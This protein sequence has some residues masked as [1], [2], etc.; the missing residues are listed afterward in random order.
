MKSPQKLQEKLLSLLKGVPALHVMP[1]PKL[2]WGELE[3]REVAHIVK[4]FVDQNPDVIECDPLKDWLEEYRF[5][6]ADFKSTRL[7]AVNPTLQG[8]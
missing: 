3:L 8:W 5:F 7:R 2:P 4:N 1:N 6:E